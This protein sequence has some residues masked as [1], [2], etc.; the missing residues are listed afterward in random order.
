M[1]DF[2]V[3]LLNYNSSKE[4]IKH[5]IMSVVKQ[6][7]VKVEIIVCDDASRDNNFAYIEE[8]L[9]EYDFVDYTLLDT[10]KNLGTVRNILRGLEIA[11]GRYA[12]LIGMGDMLYSEKTLSQV[13]EF[14]KER[15]TSCCFGRIKG[16]RLNDGKYEKANHRSPLELESYKKNNKKNISKNILIGED[17][18]SGVCIFATT[19]YYYK[20]ISLM[21]DKVIYCEDW[22]TALALIDNVYLEFIEQYVVWYEV[23]DGVSTTPNPEWRKKLL[24]DNENFWQVIEAYAREK[25]VTKYQRHFSANRRK[26][27]LDKITFKPVQFFLKALTNPYLIGYWIKVFIQGKQGACIYEEIEKG[28]LDEYMP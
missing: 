1:F 4:Q 3:I 12:K 25:K 21:R 2:S 8:L 22:A 6:R 18:V 13:S 9:A 26:K 24:A 14:M 23:G 15:N 28:F 7:D 5:T 10:E 27:K 11:K 19:E 16:Y 20:Y 17:W